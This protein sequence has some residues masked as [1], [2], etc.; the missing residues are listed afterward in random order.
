MT[1]TKFLIKRISLTVLD[2]LP[3]VWWA[4]QPV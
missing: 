1:V 4:G 2:D 3:R